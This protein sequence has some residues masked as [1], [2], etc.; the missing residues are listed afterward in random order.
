M[1]WRAKAGTP[2]RQH[3]IGIRAAPL[4]CCCVL[5]WGRTTLRGPA[6]S[7]ISDLLDSVL[8]PGPT[9]G[10]EKREVDAS[11]VYSIIQLGPEDAV[12]LLL[13]PQEHLSVLHFE[14]SKAAEKV[15][16]ETGVHLPGEVVGLATEA[17]Y[18]FCQVLATDLEAFS[19]H[20][21]RSTITTD[22]LLLFARRNPHLSDYI[23]AKAADLKPA[24]GSVDSSTDLPVDKKRRKTKSLASM[25]ANKVASANSTLKFPPKTET[26]TS[27]NQPSEMPQKSPLMGDSVIEDVLGEWFEDFDADQ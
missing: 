1:Q 12:V 14:C 3:S 2:T 4:F 27:S 26:S 5:V 13:V 10:A 18:R 7:P 6:P 24:S 20:A 21:H 16:S 19:R 11:Q 23:E 25:S 8:T 17:A 22:D 15:T 9:W